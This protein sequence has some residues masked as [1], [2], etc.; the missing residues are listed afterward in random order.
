MSVKIIKGQQAREGLQN[1]INQLSDAVKVTLG[2]KGKNVVFQNNFGEVIT[3]KDGVTVAKNIILED[4][5]ENMGASMVKEVALKTNE[6]AGDGTTSSIVL[7]QA[8]INAGLIQITNNNIVYFK[9]GI[10]QAKGD[11]IE[12]LNTHAIQLE[13]DMER[14]QQIATISA[15]NDS[16]IGD[17]LKQSF[18]QVGAN[19]VVT[20]EESKT[21]DTYVDIV[22]GMKFDRGYLSNHF[23]TNLEKMYTV[24]KNPY[25]LI[26]D[27][28]ID[29][30][31][32]L[33]PI[34]ESVIETNRPLV[35]IADDFDNDALSNLIVNKLQGGL[36]IVAVK[37]PS[38]GARK[39][40]VLND[41]CIM[42]GATLISDVNN[43]SLETATLEH[44]GSC[45]KIHIDKDNTLITE[46]EGSSFNI[47]KRISQLQHDLLSATVHYDK[48]KLEERI[49]KLSSGV[50]IIYISGNTELEMK[51]RKY[52]LEDALHAVKA[53][54]AEGF[55]SGGGLTLLRAAEY[56]K[57]KWSKYDSFSNGFLNGY[58]VVLGACY[59]PFTTIVSNADFNVDEVFIKVLKYDDNKMGFN[60][61]TGE[62]CDLLQA[63]VI[64]PKKVTRVALEN[65]VSVAL[66]VLSTESVLVPIIQ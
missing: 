11:V 54:L 65:A 41:I 47:E 25:L 15:N 52:R 18:T 14:L 53:S 4:V 50:A 2:P 8:L 38:Y 46:G 51:E 55:V 37:A 60:S 1:G 34:L 62:Y 49:G 7:A 58:E 42:T 23:C 19:G 6:L 21:R 20:I 59:V 16:F 64:D 57:T 45:G 26:T 33:I 24:Y 43:V 48:I 32:N 35:I 40:D 5:L 66:M 13:G 30:F 63:G 39:L 9:Q 61:K 27:K 36:P 31:K 10:E 29:N 17:L 56:L 28:K 22:T 12:Y 3:T 44:L